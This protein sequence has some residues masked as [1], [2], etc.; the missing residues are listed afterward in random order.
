MLQKILITGGAGYIGSLLTPKLLGLGYEV[1]VFDSLLYNQNSLLDCCIDKNFHFL[2]EDICNEDKLESAIKDKDIIIPLAAL[3]GVPICSKNPTLTRVIN[4][5][6]HLKLIRSLSEEQKVIFPST[7]SGYGV[8]DKDSECTEE[9]PQNPISDYG[10]YK[11][12][13][14]QELLKRKNSVT[15]RLATVFGISPRM[16]LDLLVNDFTHK[17]YHDRS[18][19]LFEEHFRRNFIHV[20][21][22]VD[23]FIFAIDNFDR[24]KGE[25][26]NVGLSSANLTKRELAE[27]IKFHYPDLAINSAQIGEDPDKRDYL[28]SNAKLEG[29][30]W[31]AKID[32]DEGILELLKGYKIIKHNIFSNV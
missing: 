9:T 1:T 12:Q 13:V 32:L 14:E 16:R 18:L 5:D 10:V 30:G 24:M 20:R 19:T 6:A 4:L 28:V 22:V 7:N 31:E 17:A 11:V 21:D 2:K 26:Y 27:R 23:T 3:V 15:F 29:L 8:G 25:T